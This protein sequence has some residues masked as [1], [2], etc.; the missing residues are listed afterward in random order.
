MSCLSKKAVT[1]ACDT[2]NTTALLQAGLQ[3][4]FV[5]LRLL[6]AQYSSM[7]NESLYRGGGGGMIWMLIGLAACDI[8]KLMQ[9]LV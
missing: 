2:H 5:S 4:L 9:D 7:T 8:I 6:P 3:T 1:A